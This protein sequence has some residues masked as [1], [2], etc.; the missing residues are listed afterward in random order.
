L[1]LIWAAVPRLTVLWGI[2]LAAQG[3]LPVLTIYYIKLTI[4]NFIIAHQRA[5]SFS[6]F[7]QTF[8]YFALAGFCLLAAE[9]LQ[10]TADWTR[11]AQSEYFSDYLKNLLHRQSAAVDLEF[12]ESAEYHDLTEQARGEAQSKPLAL[13]ES[14]G[15]VAQNT[16]TLI[17]FAAL[18]FS[19]GWLIPVVLIVG[20]L[21]GL[22]VALKFDRIYHGWWK[23]TAI[24]RRWLMYFDSMLSHS[25][26]AAEMR[27]FDLSG[28]FRERYQTLR[29]KLR[30]EKLR[31]LRRQ[32][33]GKI[34]AN[35]FALAV[36]GGTIGWIGLRVFYNL[37]TFGDL[38][39]FY[40]I[41]SRGQAIMRTL[42]GGV[43]QTINNSLYLESL[44]AYLDLPSK[45]T[46]P[47]NAAPF[48]KRI[49]SGIRFRDVSFR[50]P[51]AERAAVADFDLFIPAGKIAAIVGINGAGKSTLIKLLSRF[52][53]VSDGAIEID[54]TDIRRFDVEEL[55]RNISV[56]FQFPMQFHETAA[57]NISL[58]D[59]TEK[60]NQA[61]IKLAATR[62]GAHHF[63]NKLPEQY[64]TLL[65]KWF[66]NGCE[67]SGGEWQ[68]IALARA[69]FRQSPLLILD[70]PTSFM[71]SWAEADWFDRFRALAR[72][73]TA[74]VIT[75]RFTIA[76]RADVI[77]VLDDGKLIETGTHR[78]LVAADGFYA[79]SWKSQQAAAE[80]QPVETALAQVF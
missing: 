37:A 33:S 32:F 50:Y 52:Y 46:S 68:R 19:Y 11:T 58:G 31:H 18:L 44:F 66:V 54:D 38:A 69:Y 21:P 36:A 4:D 70:E 80:H 28:T 22:I 20:A 30:Y 67:L 49:E 29:R 8:Y 51:N 23:R 42:F 9:I 15:S 16:I 41:F 61:R 5:D 13:L 74:L 72:E 71:D 34:L 40:Q 6:N 43:G 60:A 1:R 62:A 17:S 27:L 35:V 77:Y 56:L 57:D 73:R 12:Y 14:L 76:M 3:L 39:V 78:E 45:I 55:R 53:D 65:G 63:I 26:A 25:A 47:E 48:P 64:E 75:H 24:E 7:N 10:F 79:E 2:L 59:T